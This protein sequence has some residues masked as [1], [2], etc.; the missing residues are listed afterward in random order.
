MYYYVN[1]IRCG[2]SRHLSKKQFRYLT[3][4]SHADIYNSPP[5]TATDKQSDRS[6]NLSDI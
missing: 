3:I 2:E 4:V 5:P 1:N 6:I